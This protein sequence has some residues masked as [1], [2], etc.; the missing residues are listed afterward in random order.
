MKRTASSNTPSM[1]LRRPAEGREMSRMRRRSCGGGG[2]RSKEEQRIISGNRTNLVRLGE[3][4]K[5]SAVSRRSPSRFQHVDQKVD[6]LL[7]NHV[8]V[9]RE[10]SGAD[11][12]SH[13]LRAGAGESQEAS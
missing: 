7:H 12:G 10:Q 3:A 5:S 4:R 13:G 9:Q 8:E 6:V 1:L 11:A 2:I